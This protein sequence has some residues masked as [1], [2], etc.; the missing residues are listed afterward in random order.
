MAEV[1]PVDFHCGARLRQ[2]RISAGVSQEALGNALG[3]TF[4]Q[5]QKYEKGTNRI[6][7]SRLYEI[8]CFFE[9]SS[10]YFFEGLAREASEDNPQPRIQ[11]NA[12]YLRD[13]LTASIPDKNVRRAVTGLIAA[14]AR[15]EDASDA[16]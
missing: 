15:S 13:Q 2:L 12:A 4:Q 7:A 9:V 10:T 5:I 16:A 8:C 11:A 3:V 1:H 6:S 14:L